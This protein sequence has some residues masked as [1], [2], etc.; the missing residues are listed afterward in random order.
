MRGTPNDADG[1]TRWSLIATAI[2]LGVLAVLL[3]IFLRQPAPAPTP[4]IAA[5]HTPSESSTREL[6]SARTLGAERAAEHTEEAR[7]PDPPPPALD[8]DHAEILGRFISSDRSPLPG[9]TIRLTGLVEGSG[10]AR[11]CGSAS[12]WHAP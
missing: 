11:A 1:S 6:E 9:V 4:S 12:N 8:R 3:F 10:R 2:A 5:D 7:A